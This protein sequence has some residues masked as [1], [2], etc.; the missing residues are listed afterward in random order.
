MKWGQYG[1]DNTYTISYFD[2][3]RSKC[4]DEES[5]FKDSPTLKLYSVNIKDKGELTYKDEIE[6]LFNNTK[7]FGEGKEESL[8]YKQNGAS[9]WLIDSDGKKVETAKKYC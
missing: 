3:Q 2:E 5:E 4:E 7:I 1:D 9:L 8:R 6:F